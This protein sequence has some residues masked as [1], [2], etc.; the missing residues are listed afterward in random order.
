MALPPPPQSVAPKM[1]MDM[2]PTKK[3]ERR[4]GHKKFVMDVNQHYWLHLSSNLLFPKSW[5]FIKLKFA[6]VK[7]T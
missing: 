7:H 2:C 1:D 5:K 4:N 3:D 6:I